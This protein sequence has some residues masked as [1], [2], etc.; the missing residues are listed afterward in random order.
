MEW[1]DDYLKSFENCMQYMDPKTWQPIPWL[2]FMALFDKPFVNYV[3]QMFDQKEKLNIDDKTLAKTLLA[4]NALRLELL[5][6]LVDLKAAKLDKQKR[7]IL[8]NKLAKLIKAVSVRDP[9]GLTSNILKTDDEIKALYNNLKWKSGNPE[10]G[11]LLGKI[12]NSGYNL[13]SANFTDYLM[14]Y[15]VDNEGP[16]DMSSYFGDGSILIIKT[17]YNLT[18]KEMWPDVTPL[19]YD[20]VQIFTVYKN[21]SYKSDLISAHGI[22]KGDVVSNLTHFSVLVD[23]KP[24]SIARL[25]EILNDLETLAISQW[26]HLKNM[27]EENKKLYILRARCFGLKPLFDKLNVDW[28]PNEEST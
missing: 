8:A 18:N 23:D 14:A 16:Y 12:Y 21:I 6:W 20:H 17:L 19:S 4:P 7:I 28:K 2:G 27:S 3:E 26:K 25:K 11:R 22:Y 15:G 10:A 1:I 24:V 13:G 5:Y 9:W